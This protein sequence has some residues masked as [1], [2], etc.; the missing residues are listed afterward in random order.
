MEAEFSFHLMVKYF[1]IIYN[2]PLSS[3]YEL[4]FQN[5]PEYMTSVTHIQNFTSQIFFM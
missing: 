3:N 4:N 2:F 5:S 1:L